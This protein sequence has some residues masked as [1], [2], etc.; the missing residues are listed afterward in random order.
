[1]PIVVG[2]HRYPAFGRLAYFRRVQRTLPGN[3][4]GYYTL[5]EPVGTTG[6]GSVKDSSGFANHATPTN[7]TFESNGIGDEKSAAL[8]NGTTSIINA[9][10][11]PLATSF[12]G[13]EGS[14]L[15]WAKITDATQW[16]AATFPTFI[17][18]FV[19]VNNYIIVQKN[20]VN[21]SIARKANSTVLS[22]IVPHGS[23]PIFLCTGM[24]WSVAGGFIKTYINGREINNVN[25]LT[26]FIGTPT[27]IF[28]GA[29]A[30][31]SLV[32]PGLM[33]HVA[34]WNAPLTSDRMKSLMR[35]YV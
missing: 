14:F 7:V 6:A 2:I 3:L 4:I 30:A 20:G 16:A 5:S 31:G 21:I 11:N 29:N 8:F 10:V 12:N 9:T 34:I 23:T 13:N 1:M 27:E 18:V 25:I 15:F 32:W 19:D 28:I 22:Y 26:N 24:T 17:R 35:V 33:A